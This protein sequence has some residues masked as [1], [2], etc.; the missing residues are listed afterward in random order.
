MLEL[1]AVS[2][3]V[4]ADIREL[5]A[6]FWRIDLPGTAVGVSTM[7]GLALVHVFR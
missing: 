4:L 1:S 6:R 7:P 2:F 3:L 5:K